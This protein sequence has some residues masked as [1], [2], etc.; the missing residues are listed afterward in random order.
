[1]N[2]GF[3]YREQVGP[4]AAGVTVLD[5]LAR[6]Y[7]HST[8]GKW[9]E[10]IEMGQVRLQQRRVKPEAT[11]R[12][13]QTLVWRRPPWE[14]PGV[15]LCFAVLYHDE[16]LLAVAKP[17]GLPTLPGGGFLEHTLGSLVRRHFPHAR[18]LH[19]LGRGT[20]G[21][22]LFGKTPLA[23]ARLAAQ[24]SSGSVIKVY[25]AR[26]GGIPERDEFSV[27]V[28]IGLAPHPLL[29]AVYAASAAGKPAHSRVQVLERRKDSCIVRIVIATGRPHQIRIHLAASGHPL[30]GDRLYAEGGIFQEGSRALPGEGGYLL[31]AERLEFRHPVAPRRVLIECIPPCALRLREEFAANERE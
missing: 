13:G 1:M 26:A 5:Y 25:R 16:Y 22:V 11:L 19:R 27:D 6:R 10:R 14:E 12:P 3:E 30:V 24:W 8:R 28:P 29:G 9:Y 18:P 20:S 17:S 7:P 21:L 4:G 31:H 23:R 2:G 15:P